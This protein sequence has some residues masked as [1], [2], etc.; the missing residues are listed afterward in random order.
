MENKVLISFYDVPI[1]CEDVK[2]NRVS[3]VITASHF[4]QE[5]SIRGM[6]PIRSRY[7]STNFNIY[8]AILFSIFPP[9]GTTSA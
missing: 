3:D 2:S 1:L 5:W 9:N 7:R 6:A 8:F 4:E